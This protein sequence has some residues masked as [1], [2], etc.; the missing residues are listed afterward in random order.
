MGSNGLLW[1]FGVVESERH[2][3]SKEILLLYILFSS[4]NAFITKIV[5]RAGMIESSWRGYEPTS[6]SDMAWQNEGLIL[7]MYCLVSPLGFVRRIWI[8][9]R[10]CN[11]TVA[12]EQPYHS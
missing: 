10:I 7:V 5:V 3:E 12:V 8:C 6:E 4:H 2:S 9:I 1:F 11:K